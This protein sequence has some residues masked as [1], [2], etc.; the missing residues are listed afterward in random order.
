MNGVIATWR[1]ALHQVLDLYERKRGAI[2]VFF[3][4][5]FLFFI[6]LNIVC[7]W[8]A[9]YTGIEIWLLTVAGAWANQGERHKAGKDA[10]NPAGSLDAVKEAGKKAASEKFPL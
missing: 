4:L 5:L 1:D 3:P 2:Q 8:W 7:Y 6:V 10:P 9:I